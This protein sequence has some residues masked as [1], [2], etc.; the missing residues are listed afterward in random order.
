MV[1]SASASTGWNVC[2][3]S[4][5]RRPGK[6]RPRR[7]LRPKCRRPWRSWF[8]R[9]SRPDPEAWGKLRF[10]S[11]TVARIDKVARQLRL[12]C[13]TLN[14]E[15][16]HVRHPARFRS[17]RRQHPDWRDR[18]RP[19]VG[20]HTPDVRGWKGVGFHHALL[21][22]EAG[23][24]EREEPVCQLGPFPVSAGDRRYDR[25]PPAGPP[26]QR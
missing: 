2:R 24:R 16:A 5:A 18:F 12:I 22:A 11:E 19:E 9:E 17:H 20:W 15:F 10:P 25:G 26:L 4:S 23:I 3:E 1:L 14:K 6:K 8:A 13:G 7:R 21:R